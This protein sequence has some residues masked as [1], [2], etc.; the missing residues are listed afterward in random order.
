MKTGFKGFSLKE[1]K[2]MS[3]RFD[4]QNKTFYLTGKE[5]SYIF[6]INDEGYLE[7]LY[8]GK[9]LSEESLTYLFDG[10]INDFSPSYLEWKNACLNVI[11]QEYAIYGRGDYRIPSVLVKMQNGSRITDFRYK[12]F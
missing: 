5:S 10:V 2:K 3:I 8:Y 9:R 1:R 6:C 11:P 7:H 12:S 4:N